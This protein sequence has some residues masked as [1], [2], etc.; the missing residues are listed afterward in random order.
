MAKEV[1]RA[2]LA[3][4]SDAL[5]GAAARVRAAL[6]GTSPSRLLGPTA[7]DLVRR[8]RAL[9]ADQR[10]MTDFDFERLA[11]LAL[12][13]RAY[14]AAPPELRPSYVKLLAAALEGG[15][16]ARSRSVRL[17]DVLRG[18][19]A[20]D[21]RLHALLLEAPAPF[22]DLAALARKVNASPAATRA[23]LDNLLRLGLVT[24]E[25]RAPPAARK[26]SGLRFLPDR[27]VAP[28][29]P[30]AIVVEINDSPAAAPVRALVEAYR[31]TELA[32]EL[33]ELALPRA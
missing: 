22:P 21:L 29:P 15:A 32:R 3:Q 13:A 18:A 4:A 25:R 12:G 11:F 2:T 9:P 17:L 33:G 8:W 7:T 28:P 23:A 24:R 30:C 5:W 1:E 6:F 16:D 31:A 14:L 19:T 26:P 27:R 10:R 20:L